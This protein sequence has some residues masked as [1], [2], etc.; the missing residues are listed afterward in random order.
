LVGHPIYLVEPGWRAWLVVAHTT[1][2]GGVGD[3]VSLIP[4]GGDVEVAATSG[5]RWPLENE[6]LIFGMARGVSN[7]MTAVTATVTVQSGRL[8][9]IHKHAT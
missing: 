2:K 7:M 4:I 6:R 3:I 9:C 1:I 5:L 8:L